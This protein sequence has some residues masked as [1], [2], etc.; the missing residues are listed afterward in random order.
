ME[1]VSTTTQTDRDT[2]GVRFGVYEATWHDVFNRVR[3]MGQAVPLRAGQEIYGVPRGGMILAGFVAQ[4]WGCR[5]TH[6]P[7]EARVIVD[8]IIDS[9]AT[10]RHFIKAFPGK[11]FVAAYNKQGSDQGLGWIV[12]PW[13]PNKVDE[14]NERHVVRLLEV[15]GERP[16]RDGLRDTPRRVISA[17]R[18]MTSGYGVNPQRHLETKFTQPDADEMVVVRDIA[19]NSLCEHHL[20]PFSGTAHVAYIPVDNQVVGLSK[21]PR[22]VTEFAARLQLQERLTAQI[23]DTL[24]HLSPDVAV[25][26]QA[27]HACMSCRGIR[28][29]GAGMVTSAMLGQF[30]S[31]P[32]ARAEFFSLVK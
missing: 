9:G 10:R 1:T 19:F 30:R 16:E 27:T 29:A 14:D 23:A 11:A 4:M 32:E 12:L 25:M 8:D 20:M 26:L 7:E 3:Q 15:V 18:E 6:K 5:L 22:I 24:T 2:V 21:L 17:L 13:E 28:Q 31:K